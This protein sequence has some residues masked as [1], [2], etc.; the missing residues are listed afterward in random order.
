MDR[1]PPISTSSTSAFATGACSSFSS[2]SQVPPAFSTLPPPI[3]S[4]QAL[5]SPPPTPGAPLPANSP[6]RERKFCAEKVRCEGGTVSI[7]TDFPGTAFL[8][9]STATSLPSRD[10]CDADAP[11]SLTPFAEL[12]RRLNSL[13][14]EAPP[15]GLPAA[16]PKPSSSGMEPPLFLGEARDLTRGPTATPHWF[17]FTRTWALQPI[18]GRAKADEVD[19]AG[20]GTATNVTR[21]EAAILSRSASALPLACSLRCCS[22]SSVPTRVTLATTVRFFRFKVAT[23]RKLPAPATVASV[24][25][26]TAACAPA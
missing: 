14:F 2:S 15:E 9:T 6:L 18:R 3:P 7:S 12:L 25:A 19:L 22:S 10:S 1:A 26:P 24:S 8:G 21:C 4:S 11:R 23:R 20:A 5:P 16:P 17:G 13:E